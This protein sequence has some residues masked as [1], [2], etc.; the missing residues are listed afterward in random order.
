M[1]WLLSNSLLIIIVIFIL[2]FSIHMICTMAFPLDF[3]SAHP[4]RD[5]FVA[6]VSWGLFESILSESIS[7]ERVIYANRT[8]NVIRK[9]VY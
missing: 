5:V 2:D 1:P 9:R 4:N 6:M 3:K 8:I 7:L